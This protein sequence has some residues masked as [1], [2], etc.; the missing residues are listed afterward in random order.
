ML[1]NVFECFVCDL[2]CGVVC[3]VAVCCVSV[4]WCVLRMTSCELLCGLCMFVLLRVCMCFFGLTSLFVWFVC[5]LLCDDV[6]F[7]VCVCASLC[8]CVCLCVHVPIV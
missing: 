8:A 3:F 2:L 5:K 6:W 1:H 4:C 7:G